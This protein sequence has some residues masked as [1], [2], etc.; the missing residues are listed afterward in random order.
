MDWILTLNDIK[1]LQ[2]FVLNLNKFWTQ[3]WNFKENKETK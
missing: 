2:E 1:G 3:S